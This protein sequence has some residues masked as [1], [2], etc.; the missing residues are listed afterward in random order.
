MPIKKNWKLFD[1]AKVLKCTLQNVKNEVVK[2][3]ICT[4]KCN[5]EM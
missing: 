1:V 5:I 3:F 4:L 2:K